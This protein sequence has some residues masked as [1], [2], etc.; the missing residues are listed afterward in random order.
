VA[1]AH[2]GG[3]QEGDGTRGL[4]AFF[5]P[6]HLRYIER[7]K[8]WFGDN[9]RLLVAVKVASKWYNYQTVV[10]A[11]DTVVLGFNEGAKQL[12]P[13]WT[14]A[15]R[16]WFES[17]M[18]FDPEARLAPYPKCLDLC[19]YLVEA[20]TIKNGIMLDPCMGSGSIPIAASRKGRR[21]VGIEIEHDAYDLT[22]LRM[23]NYG[24]PDFDYWGRFGKAPARQVS[25]ERE[26]SSC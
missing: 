21:Y 25:P 9:N 18:R 2:R 5:I 3:V 15:R 17:C 16:D 12:T 14:T 22:R 24:S 1:E 8:E 13:E 11:Y 7:S 19:E 26:V 20:F 4:L 6:S 23:H 10:S